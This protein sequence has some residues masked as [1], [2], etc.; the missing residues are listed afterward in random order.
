MADI[1]AQK[2]KLYLE[3]L[4]WHVDFCNRWLPV[5][6]L[7]KD[8]L[9]LADLAA[10][11]HDFKGTWFINACY[12]KDINK[13]IRSYLDGGIRESGKRKGETYPPNP[14]LPVLLCGNR[15]SLFGWNATTPRNEDNSF[16]KN[17]D[18]K[19]T[20]MKLFTMK[21]VE[22]YLDGAQPKVREVAEETEGE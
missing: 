22:F 20:K 21:V 2:T 6:N 4:G 14:H 5:I 10:V 9:G 3:K 1:P 15:F 13:H 11:R 17:K 8:F 16:K 12:I 19:K 7:R 18:G